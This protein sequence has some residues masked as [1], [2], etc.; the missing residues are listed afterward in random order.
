M[1]TYRFDS[2]QDTV[3]KVVAMYE[4]GMSADKIALLIGKSRASVCL[5]LKSAGVKTRR[6]PERRLSLNERFFNPVNSHESAYWLG[7]LLADGY[8]SSR[9]LRVELQ[10]RDSHHLET[11]AKDIGS[12]TTIKWSSRHHKMTGKT[13]KA[14]RL[15]L[16]S[17]DMAHSL[18]ALGWDEFKKAGDCR[19]LDSVPSDLRPS[20]VRGL[21]DGDGCAMKDRVSFV[22]KYEEPVIWF[23]S[24]TLGAVGKEFRIRPHHS[25]AEAYDFSISGKDRIQ[26]FYNFIYSTPGP[27]LDRKHKYHAL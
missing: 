6:R 26:S 22:D 9:A 10:E 24:A 21:F 13:H 11:L 23:R 3:Q 5:Y 18:R 2:M 15:C 12:T 27:F 20:L 7:F 17:S 4:S 25:G 8:L 1:R 16:S 19:I 14:A